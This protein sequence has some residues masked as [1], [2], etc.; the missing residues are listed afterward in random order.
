MYKQFFSCVAKQDGTVAGFKFRYPV[1]AW[2]F[3]QYVS[4]LKPSAYEKE[5]IRSSFCSF[6]VCNGLQ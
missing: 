1:L 2:I 6:P 5:I 4:Y 3:L